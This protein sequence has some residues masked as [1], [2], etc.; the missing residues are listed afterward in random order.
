M[1]GPS[2]KAQ[3]YS[4]DSGHYLW[5]KWGE[6]PSKHGFKMSASSDFAGL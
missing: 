2:N 6:N 1:S 4:G 5:K 3:G